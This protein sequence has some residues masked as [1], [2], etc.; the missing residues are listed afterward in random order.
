MYNDAQL[1]ATEAFSAMRRDLQMAKAKRNELAL[2][3]IQLKRDLEE[4][5]LKREQYVCWGHNSSLIITDGNKPCARRAW[6]F[7]GRYPGRF[8][9][10]RD[11]I[12]IV[13]ACCGK[14]YKSMVAGGSPSPQ[15]LFPCR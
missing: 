14:V 8:R 3:N 5:N 11:T 10:Q 13:V 2:E 1:P 15:C 12:G 7:E 4:A 9:K 6:S